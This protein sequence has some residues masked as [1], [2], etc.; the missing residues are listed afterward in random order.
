MVQDRTG[1]LCQWCALLLFFALSLSGC[2]FGPGS[3]IASGSATSKGASAAS[4]S[5][6]VTP[7]TATVT[8]GSPLVLSA[9][10]SNL[11]KPIQWTATAG[12]ISGTGTTVTYT[13]P[14]NPGT[15][16]ATAT[17]GTL[18]S[19][20]TITVVAATPAKGESI[21]VSPATASLVA[22]GTLVL[23]ATL[24]GTPNNNVIWTATAGTVTGTSTTGTY[25][26]PSTA[27]T[28][29]IT[30]TTSDG[31]VSASCI[32]NVS[33]APPPPPPSPQVTLT[34]SPTAVSI[35]A[36]TD[37][38]FSATVTGTANTNVLW[39]ALV[40]TVNGTGLSVTYTAP[41]TAGTDTLSALSLDPS[42]A[43]ANA[44]VTVTPAVAPPPP[45]QVTV[46]VSPA[47]ATIA[48]GSTLILV[49]TVS[50]TTNTTITWTATSGTIIGSGTTATYIAPA[51]GSGAT[52]IATSGDPSG[53]SG[54]A[55]LTF[56][57]P[58]TKQSV[59]I[60]MLPTQQTMPGGSTQSFTATVSGA[61]DTSVT[62]SATGGTISG[63]GSTITYTAPLIHGSYTITATANADPNQS[64]FATVTVPLP[65]LSVSPSSW[66]M[67]LGGV[68]T[69]TATVTNTNATG[70]SWTATAGS[71]PATGN[72][73]TYTAPNI[74]TIVTITVTSLADPS[75]K[76]TATVNVVASARPIISNVH[77]TATSNSCTVTWDTDAPSDSLLDLGTGMGPH[78][79]AW[80]LMPAAT[81]DTN[82]PGVTSHAATVTGL[83]PGGL[84]N[85]YLRSRPFAGGVVDTN[86]LDSGWYDGA[87]N[88]NYL[89]D[90]SVCSCGNLGRNSLPATA[91]SGSTYD[92]QVQLTG[93]GTVVQ[94]HDA[95][96]GI[97]YADIARPAAGFLN[98]NMDA[99]IG[100]L[101]TGNGE[102][103]S[104]FDPGGFVVSDP[105]GN[106]LLK[107]RASSVSQDT[108]LQIVTTNATPVGTYTVTF[109]NFHSEQYPGTSHDYSFTLNVVPPLFPAG[110]PASFPP[111]PGIGSAATTHTWIWGM[112]VKGA[113]PAACG[114]GA[115]GASAG[116]NFY[117][118]IRALQQVKAYDIANGITG[119]PSQW[120]TCIANRENGYVSYIN[121][122][123]P[124]GAINSIFM[125]SKGMS[126]LAINGDA[127][128]ATAL[129]N[130]AD[131][132]Q[133][134]TMR[135]SLNDVGFERELNFTTEA[136]IAANAAGHATKASL[137]PVGIDFML[138]HVDQ[139]VNAGVSHE[140]FLDGA[141]ADTLIHYYIDN[142]STDIR[143]PIAIKSLADHLWLNYW[144][145]GGCSGKTQQITAC[146]NYSAGMTHMG[147]DA[148]TNGSA[149]NIANLNLLIA[150]MYAWLFRMT[151]NATIPGSDGSQCLAGGGVPGQPCTYQ[152]AGDTIFL[153]GVSQSDY[154][155]APKDWD[156]D[157]RWS[158]DYV[159]WRSP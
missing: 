149:S 80:T 69:F 6:T 24:Q 119:N 88:C 37:A 151:G 66:T 133:F 143:I 65:V 114:A 8:T 96:I 62:W 89:G 139:I 137:I 113:V 48:N 77:A 38:T 79:P 21:S 2:G 105:H 95:Y 103:Y 39:S 41:P 147:I 126:V 35:P 146:F 42:G 50:G 14:I 84:Y 17:S 85:I 116:A 54:S 55:T 28:Y 60:T 128:A 122:T 32:V 135:P 22:G 123:S 158:F 117:D 154:F 157:F 144:V 125:A 81:T 18:S 124:P 61:V 111:I 76:T 129:F 75:V 93:P 46:S 5:L 4:S 87:S 52:I 99:T 19:A 16:T 56:T 121:A 90:G 108:A 71:I 110:F 74:G 92:F 136:F 132:A 127:T 73:V 130:N 57:A 15:Y 20:S 141:M 27:G 34:I 68:K 10:A 156:Q 107:I 7:A 115:N 31:T 36:G 49:A 67:G 45:T 40:G 51:T 106:G 109:N 97:T 118:G 138:G 13:A 11:S 82:P 33:P 3:D 150:P 44:I 12:A 98:L 23:T 100:G 58:P 140:P 9:S 102:T 26:A 155:Y 29:T 142:G 91:P 145:P 134:R 59:S 94:G 104:M 30:A 1:L 120:D 70:V 112:V 83:F 63:T 152:Q 53:A 148:A 131:N 72:S 153:S 25:T 43:A 101:P 47:S 64:A 86:P 159:T 78:I